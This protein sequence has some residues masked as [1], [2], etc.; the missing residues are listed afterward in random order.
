MIELKTRTE[1]A[2]MREAG[3]VVAEVLAAVRARAEVGV[4]PREL[5]ELAADLIRAAG[6]RPSFLGYHPS[7]APTPYP[8]TICTSV[9]D[10][11]VHGLPNGYRLRPGDLLSVDCAARLDGWH[12]DA[13]V[14][15]VVGPVAAADPADLELIAATEGALE[16]GIAAVRPGARLGDISHAI[17][18]VAKAAGFGQPDDL[19]GHGIGREMH[20]A[21]HLANEGRPGRGLSLR[22]GLVLAIEPMLL[23]CGGHR[24]R[25]GADGWTVYTEDGSRAAHAEHTVAVTE[26]GV[27]VLTA[28]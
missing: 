13:A 21:P 9:N 26:S 3:R 5:D 10:A 14:S 22:P 7:W 2:A 8:A 1:L 17:G 20:E 16:A 12:G 18:A 19:G 23:A 6:A 4:T 27:E 15:F 24:T 25:T 11:V 28:H